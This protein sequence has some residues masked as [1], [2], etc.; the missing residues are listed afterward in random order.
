MPTQTTNLFLLEDLEARTG[1]HVAGPPR[2]GLRL[3]KA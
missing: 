3:C 2:H 1:Y